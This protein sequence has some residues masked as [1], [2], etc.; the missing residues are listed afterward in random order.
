M[1]RRS[2]HLLFFLLLVFPAMVSATT[3]IGR[4][5]NK[6]NEPLSFANV[7]I[8]GSTKGTTTNINGFYKL[9]VPEGKIELVFRFLGYKM[10]IET[11]NAAKVE[12]VLDVVLESENYTLTEVKIQAD[13]EDPAYAIIRKTISKRKFYLNQVDE[14]SC[15]VY[16][17]GLQR[18]TKY[19][20]KLFGVEVNLSEFIDSTTGIVY[21]SESVSKYHFKKPDDIKE[22]MISSKVSG[23]NRAFSFN[24]A[25]DMNFNFYENII[26][27]EGLSQRGFISPVSANAL[28]YYKYRLDGS[29]LENGKW[30]NRIEVIP[31]RKNDPVFAGYIFIQEATWRI[32]ST[33]LYLTRD[34]Q[35]EFVDTLRVNQTFIPVD[36][37]KDEWML[38][39]VAFYFVFSAFGFEGNGNYVGV[40][41]GYE[42]NPDFEKRFFKGS[43]MKIT[44]DANKK[45]S[46]YW[47]TIRPVPLTQEESQDYHKRDSMEVIKE[48]KP[49]LDSLDKASNKFKFGNII[50]GYMHE[51]RYR[52]TEFSIASLL[53]AIQFNTVEGLNIGVGLGFEKK[54]ENRKSYNADLNVRYGF[55]NEKVSGNAAIRYNYNVKKFAFVRLEG[56]SDLVQ[57]N[58]AKPITPL[59]NTSYT[60]FVEDNYMKLYEKQYARL[61]YRIEPVNGFRITAQ[62]EYSDRTE[63]YNTTDYT[64]VDKDNKTYTPNLPETAFSFE[65]NEALKAGVSMRFRFK[66]KYVDRPDMNYIL[67]S[68]FPTL[69]ANYVKGFDKI[70]GSDVDFDRFEIGLE[71]RVRLGMLGA[72]N[73][74]GVYGKFINSKQLYFMD[75]VHFNGNQTIF[76]GF[77]SK[78]F[79][80]LEYYNYSTTDEYIQ[81][82]AEHEFGGFILNK[83][84]LI[85]KLKLNEIAGFRYLHLPGTIDY[86]ETSFGLEKLGIIRA[87][88][89]MS[90]HDGKTRTGFVLG[91]KTNIGQ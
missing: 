18:L 82:F 48:S 45:D 77:E 74:Y 73:Y 9:D 59:I 83:I 72:L 30:I 1:N 58:E 8:K 6:K 85:R 38:G 34:S 84:P 23:S 3:I 68:K 17:K 13:A 62:V 20:S 69:V 87:D 39:S 86:Y 28:F 11:V 64:W 35:I 24:Q 43:V 19:P 90:F 33:D 71:D 12:I 42:I 76:S 79:D 44:D 31:K 60:L 40:F 4:V 67:G 29:F 47:E 25:S 91:V 36:E 88:F 16:I 37:K 50:S 56:G 7:Y 41:S 22:V 46:S 32:H 53:E 89:V 54:Y 66:Q 78:R 14:F 10:R 81:V 2:P 80:L 70:L 61:T 15:D 21:L 5:T 26:S 52:K 49:Y 51:N 57:F 55:S 75:Y 65:N 63:V 27:V